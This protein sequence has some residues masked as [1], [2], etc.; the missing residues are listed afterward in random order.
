MKSFLNPNDKKEI[1]ERLRE[2]LPDSQRRWGKMTS[3]QMICHLSDSF[4]LSL[5]ERSAGS[6]ENFLTRSALKWVAL[7]SPLPW[8]RGVPTR[9]EMDQQAG[10]T[11]P[12]EFERDKREL[13]ILIERFIE[14][15]EGFESARHPFFGKMT[16]FEWMRWGYLHCDH[17]LRQFRV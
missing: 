9:P 14:R 16:E 10:G 15:P 13:E 3:H 17:H 11:K 5:G 12:V 1:L 8:V 2:V 6:V 4:R 7:Y